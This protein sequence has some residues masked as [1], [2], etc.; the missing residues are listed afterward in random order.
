MIDEVNDKI[1]VQLKDFEEKRKA[2]KK[3]EIEAEYDKKNAPVPLERIWSDK[4]L[5]K[6]FSKA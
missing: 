4:W 6:T 1:D 2:E 3:A 5:N